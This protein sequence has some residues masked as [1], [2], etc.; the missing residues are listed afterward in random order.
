MTT[1]RGRKQ[2]LTSRV[3]PPSVS[4]PQGLSPPSPAGSA[5]PA[6]PNLPSSNSL[7]S[8]GLHSRPEDP[9]T[10]DEGL[11]SS[12]NSADL[13]SCGS[14]LPQLAKDVSASPSVLQELGVSDK[15][16]SIPI[17]VDSGKTPIQLHTENPPPKHIHSNPNLSN[18]PNSPT[19]P[20]KPTN[21]R[22]KDTTPTSTEDSTPTSSDNR[23]ENPQSLTSA[24]PTPPCSSSPS[25]PP[26]PSSPQQPHK[27][28]D[29]TLP[30]SKDIRTSTP[31]QAEP[32]LP[33]GPEQHQRQPSEGDSKKEEPC[34]ASVDS[35]CTV[36][37][38]SSL[39]KVFIKLRNNVQLVK[40]LCE[41]DTQPK[42]VL[43]EKHSATKVCLVKEEGSLPS[44][45]SAPAVENVE[46][47]TGVEVNNEETTSLFS[48]RA[49]GEDQQERVTGS[50]ANCTDDDNKPH[51][52]PTTSGEEDSGRKESPPGPKCVLIGDSPDSQK[53]HP[54]S[55][56]PG[57]PPQQEHLPS[58]AGDSSIK[59]EQF[60]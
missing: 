26:L 3:L 5:S 56:V 22:Q 19:N 20:D 10:T 29:S 27:D 52:F 14:S 23:E 1:S 59:G 50:V 46:T 15:K 8:L 45:T 33:L 55:P 58:A 37:S 48:S 53:N 40:K 6:S 34:V 7:K 13:N 44:L 12:A 42:P 54:S 31:S 4:S 32:E 57:T 24:T 2:V 43:A 35:T 41:E 51:H 39:K 25:R 16:E 21:P 11:S 60:F 47:T 18:S 30:D 36:N 49:A 17:S 28:S 9:T 38:G